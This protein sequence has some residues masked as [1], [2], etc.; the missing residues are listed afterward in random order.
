MTSRAE[1]YVRRLVSR[2]ILSRN[3]PPK[4]TVRAVARHQG[5]RGAPL[6]VGP[7]YPCDSILHLPWMKTP[8]A[9]LIISDPSRSDSVPYSDVQTPVQQLDA[10]SLEARAFMLAYLG[11]AHCDRNR[12]DPRQECDSISIR[13][14]LA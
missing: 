5:R 7:E 9:L 11:G 2:D 13:R 14:F 4:D 10:T 3:T 12:N 8:I 1:L 6:F